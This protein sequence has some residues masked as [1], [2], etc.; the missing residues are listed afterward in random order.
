MNYLV[1][2]GILGQKWGK[3]NGPPYP[4]D[5]SKLS[6][7]EREQAKTESIQKG[8]IQTASKNRYYY[9]NKE[10]NE[11]IERFNLN[12]K[13]SAI[14]QS[15]LDTG[16]KRVEQFC[17][18]MG[19]VS[20]YGNKAINGYNTI[21]KIANAFGDTSMPIIGEKSGGGNN[22]NNANNNNAKNE[23]NKKTE[24]HYVNGELVDSKKIKT[25]KNGNKV[26]KEYSKSKED[27]DKEAKKAEK[28]AKKAKKD[29]ERKEKNVERDIN[30]TM[31]NIDR[32]NKRDS[33][34]SKVPDVETWTGEVEGFGTNS[35]YKSGYEFVS[36]FLL[37][38]KKR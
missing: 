35:T 20:E 9:T 27:K 12:Q 8:D 4:L 11:V 16:M 25:D 5:F 37:E 1:H 30:K 31:K 6:P 33:Q 10:I 23:N 36:N 26:T 19:K 32:Q 29:Q 17:N 13:L 18:T 21:A 7:A 38:D 2:H 28:E 24:K 15:T 22:N 34:Y 3:K 14:N